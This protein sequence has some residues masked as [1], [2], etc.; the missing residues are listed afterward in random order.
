ML[1]MKRGIFI[2]AILLLILT[3]TQSCKKDISNVTIYATINV[4][5]TYQY[6][7]GNF[8]DEEG[9]TISSQAI[10]F[11][12]SKI[13]IDTNSYSK[14]YYTYIPAQNYIGADEVEI[15]SARGSDGSGSGFSSR[16]RDILVTLIKFTISN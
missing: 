11:Q 8:G 10:H 1:T 14:Y 2:L 6:D 4:N 9:A 15:T 16:N 5:E 3:S 13:E 12:I 7:L